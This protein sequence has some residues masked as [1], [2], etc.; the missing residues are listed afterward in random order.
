LRP[1]P[2]TAGSAEWEDAGH[3][4]ATIFYRAPLDWGRA[5]H[6]WA[7]DHG[8]ALSGSIYTVYEI[9]TSGEWAGNDF[10]ALDPSVLV[11]ALEALER[12]ALAE[13]VREEGATAVDEVGVKFKER[14]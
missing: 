2:H 5:I 8:M 13:L 12:E 1:H 9:R 10:C 3:T 6:S 11:R 14:R 4:R 7:V